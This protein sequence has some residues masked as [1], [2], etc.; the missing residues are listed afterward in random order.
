MGKSSSRWF[1]AAWV[2]YV[3]SL[4]RQIRQIGLMQ[5]KLAKMQARIERN[6]AVA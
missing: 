6:L 5:Q 3:A 2:L 4:E 1:R